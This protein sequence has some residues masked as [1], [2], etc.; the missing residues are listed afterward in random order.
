M[1]TNQSYLPNYISL[2]RKIVIFLLLQF[3]L[4]YCLIPV[5]GLIMYGINCC[6][7]TILQQWTWRYRYKAGLPSSYSQAPAR[8]LRASLNYFTIDFSC[9]YT[10]KLSLDDFYGHTKQ[11]VQLILLNILSSCMKKCLNMINDVLL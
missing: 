5:R 2:I 10:I 11:F 8:F 4:V 9:E 6:R 1:K 3:L 7:S